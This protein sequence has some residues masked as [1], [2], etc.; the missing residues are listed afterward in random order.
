[1]KTKFY[2]IATVVNVSSKA[3]RIERIAKSRSEAM[4]L[5]ADQL[6]GNDFDPTLIQNVSKGQ[7]DSAVSVPLMGD[8]DLK[9]MGPV[10][11][12]S[13]INPV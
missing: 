13:P 2:F 10:A 12:T 3:V 6:Y 11:L 7:Y 9:V 8:P 1:M 5:A 4:V